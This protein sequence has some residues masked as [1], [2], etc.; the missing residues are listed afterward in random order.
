MA[1]RS[2]GFVTT[3]AGVLVRLTANETDPTTNLDAH[4][5]MAEALQGNTGRVY[6][7][8]SAMVR[9]TGVGVYAV[10]PIPTSNILPTFTATIAYAPAALLLNE[11][12]LDVDVD[13]EGVLVSYVV[14]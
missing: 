10:I 8:S 9:A 1:I 11:L 6:I 2:A 4:S 14:G 12:F 3:T 13:N 5:I 7:G